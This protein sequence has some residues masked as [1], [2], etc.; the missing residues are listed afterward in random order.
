MLAKKYLRIGEA[1]RML[2]VGPGRIRMLAA[3]GKLP[4]LRVGTG[5][6]RRIPAAA[7]AAMQNLEGSAMELMTPVADNIYTVEEAAHYLGVTA[8]F[9][10]NSGWLASQRGKLTGA[11]IQ[12]LEQGL[13][14]P[15]PDPIGDSAGD[16][17]QEGGAH[18]MNRG[19]GGPFG[20]GWE[21][22]WDILGNAPWRNFWNPDEDGSH[23]YSELG[24][25]S[26]KRHLEAARDNLDDRIQWID[27]QLKKM[28]DASN[29]PPPPEPSDR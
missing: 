7:V 25:R 12:T 18:H 21:M 1:A 10:W 4:T 2:G 9:L 6:H 5:G 15:E 20:G 14:G 26:M 16:R 22:M 19:M 11:E 3:S 27:E 29:N 23:R 24:L 8:R 13:Y 28:A 17:E